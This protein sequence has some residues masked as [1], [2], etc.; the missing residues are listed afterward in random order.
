VPGLHE[1]HELSQYA[2][3]LDAEESNNHDRDDLAQTAGDD[4][5]FAQTVNDDETET[6][7]VN[8]DDN[9]MDVHVF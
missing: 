5:D 6:G 9:V 8:G 7:Q 1:T 3:G 4:D 2:N